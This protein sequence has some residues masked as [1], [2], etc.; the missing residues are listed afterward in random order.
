LPRLLLEW[1]CCS[2]R[3]LLLP[4]LCRIQPQRMRLPLQRPGCAGN[5]KGLGAVRVTSKLPARL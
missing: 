2:L 1:R 3:L 4:Q 5:G